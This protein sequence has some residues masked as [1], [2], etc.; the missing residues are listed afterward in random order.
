MGGADGE[1]G[2]RLEV[3]MGERRQTLG[4]FQ[5]RRETLNSGGFSVKAGRKKHSWI[6]VDRFLGGGIFDPHQSR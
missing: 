1:S 2:G 3:R 6:S 4:F 5:W